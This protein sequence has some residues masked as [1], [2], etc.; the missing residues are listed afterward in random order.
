MGFSAG[1]HLASTLGTHFDYGV[2]DAIDP[3]DQISSRP[4]F[5][6]LVY[7]V[8]SFTQKF[9]SGSINSRVYS[10]LGIRY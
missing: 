8:V 9:H 7:P 2:K 6:A 3:I 10:V 1:G 5:M 4:D